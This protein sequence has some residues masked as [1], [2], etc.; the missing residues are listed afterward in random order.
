MTETT[1]CTARPRKNFSSG[2]NYIRNTSRENSIKFILNHA[3]PLSGHKVKMILILISILFHQNTKENQCR[4]LKNY[5]HL[6][7][8]RCF[9]IKNYEEIYP[10]NNLFYIKQLQT[11]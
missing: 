7:E 3:M 9:K 5:F 10:Q 8:E 4:Q 11:P 1:A 2:H 6:T